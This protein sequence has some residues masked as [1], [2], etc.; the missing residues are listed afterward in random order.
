MIVSRAEL[1]NPIF[2]DSKED[3][4]GKK[5][6]AIVEQSSPKAKET[7][8]QPKNSHQELKRDVSKDKK[9]PEKVEQS[10]L[11]ETEIQSRKSLQ[12]PKSCDVKAVRF[13]NLPS[14]VE[15]VAG[16]VKNSKDMTAD[17]GAE[18][19]ETEPND[20]PK[21][22]QAE[23]PFL[24]EEPFNCTVTWVNN[25]E[26]FF[27]TPTDKSKDFEDILLNTQDPSS[28][29]V[30]LALDTLCLCE[31]DDIW[32]RARIEKISPDKS[33]V[34]VLLVDT[35][36]K[37]TIVASELRKL[38]A[39]RDTPGLAT[40]VGLAGIRPAGTTW[41]DDDIANFKTL[42]DLEGNMEFI[43]KIVEECDG[44][45]KVEMKDVNQGMDIKSMLI[46]LGIAVEKGKN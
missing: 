39:Y 45:P 29:K 20:E 22:S 37:E 1:S 44:Q 25:P 8:M 2:L 28:A 35:G 36:R 5:S 7:E 30:D 33:K 4:A 17:K 32:Y 42:V 14:T 23:R 11:K 6:P 9:S 26:D 21:R 12:E 16:A 3:T 10:S 19:L 46:E 31:V 18:T 38:D 43:A 15:S 24:P 41:A 13:E 27:I 34:K 40:K